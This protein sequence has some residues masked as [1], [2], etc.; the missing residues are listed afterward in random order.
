LLLAA[1]L[2]VMFLG[3]ALLGC[4]SGPGPM[5]TALTNVVSE[6]VVPVGTNTVTATNWVERIVIGDE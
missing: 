6:A 1:G 2:L 5:Y 4:A 3:M